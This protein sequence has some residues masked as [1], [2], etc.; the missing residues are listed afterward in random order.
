ML[1]HNTNFK[2]GWL[3]NDCLTCIPG[4]K[5]FWHFLLEGVPGL[6]DKTMGHTPFS[7]L[8]SKIETQIER[9]KEKPDYIIRNA[10]FFGSINTKIPTISFLQ[11]PYI[12]NEYLFNQQINVCNKSNFVVYN[13]IY[14]ENLYKK[15]IKVPSKVINIGVDTNFFKSKKLNKNK[16]TIIFVGSSNEEF[17]R[18]S[19]V[20][21]IINNTNYKFILVMKD[22]YSFKHP[23]VRFF[24]KI[25]QEKLVDLFSKADLLIC[26][27][28]KETLHLA[29][30]EAAFCGVPIVASDVGV[31]REI[32]EDKRWG[33]VVEEDTVECF[34]Y[35]IKQILKNNNLE[36]R[37]VMLENNLSIENTI[38][39]WKKIIKEL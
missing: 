13:S 18:F 4:T 16:N 7:V 37:K 25:K 17:K 12:D 10:T 15:F 21:K 39:E 38:L 1:Q 32:K 30:I 11:D 14:T 8:S 3:V 9:V 27:S 5:T 19:L 26:T 23:R 2:K 6:E 24:N 33:A 34:I 29:G 35:K 22:D 20:K 28:K 36:P 31:Y